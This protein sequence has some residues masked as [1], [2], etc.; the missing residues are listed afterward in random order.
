[1]RLTGLKRL[2]VA[3]GVG[4]NQ[5]LRGQL[6]RELT[7]TGCRVYYPRSEFCTDNGAM[8][9]LAGSLRFPPAN[10]ASGAVQA[11]ARWDL[12]ELRQP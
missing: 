4:A 5:R 11:R 7:A 3:G 1:M 10:Q 9:A 8:V 12:E 6:R 2:V